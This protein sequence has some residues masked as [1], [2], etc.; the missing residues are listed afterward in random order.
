[1]EKYNF[2]PAKKSRDKNI[3]KNTGNMAN[4]FIFEKTKKKETET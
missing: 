4:G 3:T 1:M 2:G